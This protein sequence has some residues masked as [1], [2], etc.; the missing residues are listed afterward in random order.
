MR[1]RFTLS[2]ILL[3][4]IVSCKDKRD[5]KVS[6]FN[7]ITVDSLYTLEVPKYME[8]M[9]NLYNQASLQYG[10]RHKD[11]YTIVINEDK[12][13][14]IGY[15]RKIGKYNEKL[16][17]IK[18]Y[19]AAQVN[20]FRV[21]M[22]ATKIEQYDLAQINK[23]NAHQFRIEHKVNHYKMAYLIAYIETEADLFVIMNWTPLDKFDQLESTFETINKSFKYIQSNPKQ[24]EI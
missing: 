6:D 18:N 21:N 23:Y 17:V 22:K 4:V 24:D 14:F 16:S 9:S 13:D 3:F 10:S 8:T 2:I 20:Y 5:Q 7:K 12:K 1:M 15:F 19:A 11:A